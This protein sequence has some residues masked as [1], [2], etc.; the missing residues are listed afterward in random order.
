MPEAVDVIVDI[1]RKPNSNQEMTFQISIKA[2]F[3]EVT[4]TTSGTTTY[5]TTSSPSTV[6]TPSSSSSTSIVTTQ[7]PS[8]TYTTSSSST[9][10]IYTS[11][12][13]GET[14]E[15]S[16]SFTSVYITPTTVTTEC[17]VEEGMDEPQFIPNSNIRDNRNKVPKN[18]EKL[19][20][21]SKQP[22]SV[23]QNTY[24]L[25][26]LFPSPIPVES[27]EL[28]NPTNVESFT[29]TYTSPSRPNKDEPVAEVR[30]FFC[31]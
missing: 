7:V 4:G 31:N 19:R 2:C 1:Y 10:G 8:S 20:P 23:D 3:K 6:Y 22:F 5:E 16:S 9:S 13:S 30:T 12:T 17:T 15:T 25:T 18:V 14:P 11:S 29:V 24:T 21:R 26:F 28:Q 27:V